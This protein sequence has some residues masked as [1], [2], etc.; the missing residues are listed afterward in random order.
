MLL[1]CYIYYN[2][3]N[4]NEEKNSMYIDYMLD[5]NCYMYEGC[6]IKRVNFFNFSKLIKL[7]GFFKE[8]FW[9]NYRFWNNFMW[10]GIL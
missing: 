1:L 3:W 5:E 4:K 7:F 8:I 2:S 6:Y 9:L 10:I